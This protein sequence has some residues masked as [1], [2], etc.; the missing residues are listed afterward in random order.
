MTLPA[1]SHVHSEWS[2]DTGGPTSQAA[3]RMRATCEHAVRIGLGAIYFTEHLDIPDTWR[4]EPE[5]LMAYQ[6]DFL[7]AAGRVDFAPFDAAGYLDA[8][9]RM[10]HEFPDLHIH[11]GVEFGQPHLMGRRA[12]QVV[13]LDL[14]DRVLGSLHT[15]D[16]GDGPAEPHTLYRDHDPGDVLHAYLAQVR[17]TVAGSDAFE[18][19]THID[20]AVRTW[21]VATAGPFDPRAFEDGFRA[22]LQSIADGG[23]ALEMN[24]RRLWPWIPEWW[25]DAGGTAV[26]FGSDAHT[27][28]AI[29]SNFP[30]A[31][32]MLEHFG[33]RPGRTL[34]E[35]WTR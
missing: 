8:V 7:N 2:W 29:A 26:T 25:A 16:L 23:R 20:Y 13:D 10:R 4:A 12:A 6:Q 32:A 35:F 3:G 34:E 24:T 21:P 30:E 18:V 17:V 14:I 31:T 28:D 1:D 19:F 15:L 22:A 5:D 9:D 11:T 27:P 33:F